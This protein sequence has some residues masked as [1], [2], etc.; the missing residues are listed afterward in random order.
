[1][2]SFHQ[3]KIFQKFRSKERLVNDMVTKYKVSK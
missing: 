3:G 2:A 1:M